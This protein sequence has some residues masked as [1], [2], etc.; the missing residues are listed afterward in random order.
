M[1]VLTRLV[2]FIALLIAIVLFVAYMTLRG[3]LARLDGQASVNG[4][5]AEVR[6]TRDALGIP[7]LRASTRADLFRAQGYV[8]AQER[9]FQ[10]DLSRRAAAGR[11]S[12]LFGSR[13]LEADKSVRVHGLSLV[14]DEVIAQMPQSRRQWLDAY[15]AGVNAGL[16]NLRSRPF[17]YHMLRAEPD[18]WAARDTV[19]VILAMFLKLTD[20]DAALDRQRG[21]MFEALPADA[22]RWLTAPGGDWDAPLAGP[23]LP[24][25]PLPATRWFD[26]PGSADTQVAPPRGSNSFALTGARTRHGAAMLANDMHLGL[27]VPNIWFRVHL[28]E[29]ET[30]DAPVMEAVGASLPGVPGIVVGSNTHIA[31]GFT[32]SYGDYSDRVVLRPSGSPGRYRVPRGGDTLR[33]REERIEVKDGEPVILS[34]PMSRFGPVV[35]EDIRRRPVAVRWTAHFAEAV[36]LDVLDMLDV[37][38]VDSGLAL[39]QRVGIPPQNILVV[40]RDGRAGWTIAGRLPRRVGYDPSRPMMSDQDGGWRGWL[41]PASYPLYVNPPEGRLWTANGRVAHVDDVALIG[42]GNYPLGIRARQIRDRLYASDV[43]SE[44]DALAVALDTRGVF[45]ERWRVLLRSL[46]DADA[47]ADNAD[48]RKLLALLSRGRL[49]ADA[50]SAAYRLVRA[51][52]SQVERDLMQQF[53]APLDERPDIRVGR[54]RQ[55]EHALWQTVSTQPAH[56][57]PQGQASWKTYLLDVVDAQLGAAEQGAAATWGEANRLAMAHP[58]ADA[59]PLGLGRFLRMPDDA[60]PGDIFVPRVQAPSFGASQRLVVAP[61]HEDEGIFH[62]PG[63][64]SGHPL[65]PFFSA[66]HDD[67]VD[68]RAS[69]LMPGATRYTLTLVPDSQGP[70]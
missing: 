34:V 54:L 35:A 21:L 14:A 20:E 36:N 42:A 51:F 60:L 37:R 64:Q 58:L 26:A 70:P 69:P 63:G 57:L 15:V 68:G 25:P 8:H 22:Y 65:S 39:A 5:S 67:W 47:V 49:S 66:G 29:G 30:A 13:A 43:F 7:T 19:L 9:Y 55:R 46:L 56:L 4:L 27:S 62:M 33:V 45:L 53:L 10:M 2:A 61:G 40:G 44:S 50:D 16:A 24:T 18:A 31:W 11:L 12:E 32:N 38:D 17:E 23:A 6:V 48:R 41:P 59:L 1:R 3:S 52:R 28:V